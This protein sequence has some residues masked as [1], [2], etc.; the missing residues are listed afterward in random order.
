[1]RVRL[2]TTAIVVSL[3]L[4]GSSTISVYGQVGDAELEQR[5]FNLGILR[6]GKSS[7]KSKSKTD[8]KLLLAQV[9]KDFTDIQVTNNDL[10][11]RLERMTTLDLDVVAKA[12]TELNQS[13][14]RLM[15]NLTESK[16]KIKEPDP[17]TLATTHNT[18]KE[19]LAKLDDLIVEFTHNRVFKEASPED[20]KLAAKALA[21]LDQVILMSGRILKGIEKLKTSG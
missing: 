12:V 10:A 14:I 6:T 7:S 5:I 8:P 3:I 1:M 2:W 15:D 11:E 17:A 20:D 13:A 21:D 16:T 9:Q 4:L 18:L 19:Q